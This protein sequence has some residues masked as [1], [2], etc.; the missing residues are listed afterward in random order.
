MSTTQWLF[1]FYGRIGRGRWW[2]GIAATLTGIV[3]TVLVLTLISEIIA[4][5]LGPDPSI[6]GVI[7]NL[8]Y[9]IGIGAM[10]LFIYVYTALS[11]KR[12]HD[13]DFSGWWIILPHGLFFIG[14]GMLGAVSERS[15]AFDQGTATV[16][17]FFGLVLM[18]GPA[19]CLGSLP[20]KAGI[21]RPGADPRAADHADDGPAASR[22]GVPGAS[23]PPRQGQVQSF[24]AEL[25]DLQKLLEDGL[26]TQ[27]E[28]AA[29]KKQILGI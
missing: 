20:G 24:S 27:E 10:V 25:R 5:M 22:G 19:L 8:G 29:K 15:G 12:L 14:A 1:S 16:L 4:R 2:A 28:Y 9:A 26:I 21:I 13:L 18:I 11:V 17:W 6:Y 7:Y 3:A 23:P